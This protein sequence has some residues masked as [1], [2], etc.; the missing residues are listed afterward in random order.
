MWRHATGEAQYLETGDSYVVQS[1]FGHEEWL[2][3]F[4]WM[5][6]GYNY[7]F[8]QPINK[9]LHIF[10]N[11][12]GKRDIR[13]YTR[14]PP[15]QKLFIA[16]LRDVEIPSASER[17]SIFRHYQKC[18]RLDQMREELRLLGVNDSP[19][20]EP[21]PELVVN[22]KFRP[23]KVHFFD[24]RPLVK[25]RHKVAVVHYYHPLDWDDDDDGFKYFK[26][27]QVK[28]EGSRIRAA[29]DAV[30]YDPTHDR[31]QNLLYAKLRKK[32]GNDAVGY[33]QNRVDLT[34]R[35]SGETIFYE[36]KTFPVA[37]QCIRAALGQLLEYAHYSTENRASKLIIVSDAPYSSDDEAYLKYIRSMYGLPIFYARFD[38]TTNELSKEV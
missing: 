33:E 8:L 17:E 27:G 21:R 13:L 35:F 18:G 11:E 2:F 6:D 9:L 26:S 32:Y 20:N 25:D 19:L 38:W 16:D 4:E 23:E 14:S 10:E 15:G 29:V 7:G 12:R 36:I 22:V 28:P 31:L 3:N 34:V 37:K 24:P 5:V 30:E 1:G